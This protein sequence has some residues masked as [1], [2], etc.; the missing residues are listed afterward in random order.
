MADPLTDGR[1]ARAYIGLGSNLGSPAQQLRAALSALAQLPDV[2]VL[3]QS[4]LYRS[5][6]MGEAGQADY[7]NAACCIETT[8]VPQTL[9]EALLAIERAAGRVR[10]GRKWSPRILDLDLLHYEGVTLNSEALTLPHPGIAQRNFVLWPLLDIAPELEIPG[11][12]R[13]RECAERVGREGLELW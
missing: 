9:M 4:G 7:C 12:G 2:R 3:A 5:A 6:P 11:L 8:L 13:I 1:G 10:D